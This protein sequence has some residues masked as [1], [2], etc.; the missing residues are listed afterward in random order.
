M[1][2]NFLATKCGGRCLL[3]AFFIVLSLLSVNTWAQGT[4]LGGGGAQAIAAQA[5]PLAPV[6]GPVPDGTLQHPIPLG[7]RPNP[8][9]IKGGRSQSPHNTPIEGA[10]F[11]TD[12]SYYV[13]KKDALESCRTY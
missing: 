5:Q 11:L 9:R 10:P 7:F 2:A 13:E 8:A 3:S 4:T 1:N 12:A 6:S